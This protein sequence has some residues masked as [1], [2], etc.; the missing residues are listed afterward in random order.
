MLASATARKEA[1]IIYN[2]GDTALSVRGDA[3]TLWVTAEG[4]LPLCGL[5]CSRGDTATLWVT[6]E[7]ILA[8][9]VCQRGDTATLWVTAEGIL[10]LSVCQRIHTM[11]IY[12][13]A[14][15]WGVNLFKT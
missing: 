14:A 7:G 13:R 4:I 1:Y 15:Y 3:F 9:S 12:I 5:H 11:Y 10:P 2:R 8:L 6:A